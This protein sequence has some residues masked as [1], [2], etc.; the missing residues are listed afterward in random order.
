[1]ELRLSGIVQDEIR[2]PHLHAFLSELKT[3]FIATFSLNSC[4]VD[5]HDR[6]SPNWTD[7]HRRFDHEDSRHRPAS[8]LSIKLAVLKLV[9][10]VG[11]Y[12]QC[13]ALAYVVFHVAERAVARG[14]FH[15]VFE[16]ITDLEEAKQLELDV[17]T[18]G[19][20]DAIADRLKFVELILKASSVVFHVSPG[21]V[22]LRMQSG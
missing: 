9:A 11:A 15:P 22:G 12:S 10:D 2:L 21:R 5:A 4:L 18:I 3:A 19:R 14:V 7:S 17:P 20:K 1:M 13:R 8:Q 6:G 16:V